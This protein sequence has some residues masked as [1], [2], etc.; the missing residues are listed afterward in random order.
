MAA[1]DAERT[2]TFPHPDG[3]LVT[4]EDVRARILV[5]YLERL[6]LGSANIRTETTF[7][8]RLGRTVVR[9]GSD[10]EQSSLAGRLDLLVQND[11][12]ENLFVVEVKGPTEKLTDQDRDQAISY[13]RLLE[14]IAP[15]AVVTNGSETRLYDTI[16]LHRLDIEDFPEGSR[17]WA[18]GRNPSS[19]GLPGL[20]EEAMRMFF[21]YNHENVRRFSIAQQ[22]VRMRTLRGSIEEG[23]K[24][25]PS[26]YIPRLVVREE[27][28][29]FVASR[30]STFALIGAAG[31]GKTNEICALAEWGSERH[32]TL[33]FNAADLFDSLM[34]TLAGEFN[35]HFSEQLALPRMIE[36]L[37][38]LVTR[39][40]MRMLIF[41]DAVDES[42]IPNFERELS[43]V[44]RRFADFENIK[45]I[46]SANSAQWDRFATFRVLL[47]RI[48][49]KSV[50]AESYTFTS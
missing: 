4:E 32:I 28:E 45:L 42:V 23:R 3:Q 22:D 20:R 29:R 19:I 10:R 17:Y 47:Q 1:Q 7:H 39:A 50:D 8:V 36:R 13:A 30:Y 49:D 31:V 40:D 27:F 12:G 38:S 5:P 25:I 24:Y 37:S 16:T 46:I 26:L 35:W 2:G 11:H 34:S 33:F 21:G 6:G 48:P 15:F 9:V 44:T 43:E 18:S 14:H 41:V